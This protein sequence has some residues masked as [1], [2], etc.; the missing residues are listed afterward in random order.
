MSA[1]HLETLD[2]WLQWQETLHPQ[3]IDL[4]LERVATV[5]KRLYPESLIPKV[6]TIAGTNGKGS[7][8]AYLETIYQNAGYRVGCYTSPH[9]L[10]YNERIRING[11][12]ASDEAICRA[13]SRIETIRED[14]SLTY[15]EFG[16]LAALDIFNQSSLDVMILEVGLGGRLDAVNIIDTDVAIITAID[17]DHMDWLGSDRNT[18]AGEK[19]GIM[20]AHRPVI[21]SDPNPPIAISEHALTIGAHLYQLGKD[22]TYQQQAK[23][24]TMVPDVLQES[25]V[26]PH[27]KLLGERQLDNASGALKAVDILK[28]PL[29]VSDSAMINGIGQACV[30]GRFQ[31]VSDSPQVIVDVAHNP[32]SAAFL[33]ENIKRYPESGNRYAIV[34]MLADKDQMSVIDSLKDLFDGWYVAS[35]DV[36]RGSD[37]VSLITI[38]KKLEQKNIVSF[39]SVAQAYK[40]ALHDAN[41]NDQLFVFGS[42][43]TVASVLELT[44]KQ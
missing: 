18:I 42:F 5:Y 26:F 35:L 25:G 27:P 11:A 21:C 30:T 14:I 19:A 2:Q 20:R 32:Q 12:N 38:L 16:T 3:S 10:H 8:A 37:A 9:L 1:R 24:W 22:Y 6:I 31:L 36:A 40:Q 41:T 29:P 17:L 44:E 28:Q 39:Q 7:T 13:F 15:F 34:A 33:A 23:G 4:G 43:Y